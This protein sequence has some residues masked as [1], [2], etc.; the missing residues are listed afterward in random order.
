ME[1]FSALLAICAGNSK[2]TGEFPTQRPVTRSFCVF[3]DKRL[4]ERWSK[5]S[6]GWWFGRP[7][8][9]LWR[10]SN[11]PGFR[12]SYEMTHKAWSSVEEVPYC[13]SRSCVKFQCHTAKKIIDVDPNSVFPD[14]NSS[15]NSTMALKWCTKLDVVKKR[16]PIVFQGHLS[17]FKVARDKK[18]AILTRIECFRTV[19]HGFEKMHKAWRSIEK[20]PYC[21]PRS[22]MKFQGH[23]GLKIANF[24]PNWG[25]QTVT[26]VWIHR[27]I[28]NDI[29]SLM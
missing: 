3:Y 19:T 14:F 28:W 13:F 17:N 5:Q 15:L 25:F 2:V 29:Q 10:H 12:R 24:D 7:S 8:R 23:M 1:T 11:E 6:W 27:W 20:V 22:S 21:F 4:N 9:P 26:P 18:A 16:C